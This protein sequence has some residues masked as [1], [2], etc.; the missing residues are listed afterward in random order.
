MLVMELPGCLW[1]ASQRLTTRVCGSWNWFP[2]N[3]CSLLCLPMDIV[4]VAGM[5]ISIVMIYTWQKSGAFWTLFTAKLLISFYTFSLDLMSFSPASL[6]SLCYFFFIF[7]N[8][9]INSQWTMNCPPRKEKTI[10]MILHHINVH[11]KDGSKRLI[12]LKYLWKSFF[13]NTHSLLPQKIV[14][15]TQA[16]PVTFK[17]NTTFCS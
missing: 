17:F 12:F 14:L 8:A 16:P 13:A 3:N 9:L 1:S 7:W 11:K 10:T 5:R 2:S 15:F 4:L 6:N